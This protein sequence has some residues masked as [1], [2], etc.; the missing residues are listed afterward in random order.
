MAAR[1][2]A[3]ALIEGAVEAMSLRGYGT[4]YMRPILGLV[5]ESPLE[6]F[7]GGFTLAL[8]LMSA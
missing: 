8:A 4:W 3:L 7:V 6:T 2:Q 1:D 5:T